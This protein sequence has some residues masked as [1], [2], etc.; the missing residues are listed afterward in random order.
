MQDKYSLTEKDLEKSNPLSYPI[1]IDHIARYLTIKEINNLSRTCQFIN[2]KIRDPIGNSNFSIF[3]KKLST[4]K[5]KQ[6]FR[7]EPPLIQS[8]SL[9]ET[10]NPHCNAITGRIWVTAY[11]DKENNVKIDFIDMLKEQPSQD[12]PSIETISDDTIKTLKIKNNHMFLGFE[13][14]DIIYKNMNTQKNSSYSYIKSVETSALRDLLPLN[15]NRFLT[16]HFP[17]ILNHWNDLDAKSVKLDNLE[18][19][20]IESAELLSET[21]LVLLTSHRQDDYN[22]IKI[23]DIHSWKQQYNLK[24]EKISHITCSGNFIALYIKGDSDKLLDKLTL[25]NLKNNTAKNI[26]LPPL[27]NRKDDFYMFNA[28]GAADSGSFFLLVTVVEGYEKTNTALYH[29][30]ETQPLE[31]VYAFPKNKQFLHASCGFHSE[32]NFYIIRHG[33]SSHEVYNFYFP[34]AKEEPIEKPMAKNL[35][36][37]M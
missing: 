24:W 10:I 35:C 31:K 22:E 29:F 14:G 36:R 4:T 30:S 1:L 8:M 37:I 32:N 20:L 6:N 25:W 19:C 11:Q 16:L 17:N 3:T 12:Y 18:N 21:Q 5:R 26:T 13:S 33:M 15:D 2:K 9:C 34:S 28:M 23:Y 27:K 7:T